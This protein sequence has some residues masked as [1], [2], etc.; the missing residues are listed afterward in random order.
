VVSAVAVYITGS[1]QTPWP[2]RISHESKPCGSLL[3]CHLPILAV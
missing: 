2:G 1:K 3:R